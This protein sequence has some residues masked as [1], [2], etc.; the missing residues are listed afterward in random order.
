MRQ[1]RKRLFCLW[2]RELSHRSTAHHQAWQLPVYCLGTR[3]AIAVRIAARE[4]GRITSEEVLARTVSLP[5]TAVM[6]THLPENA[7]TCTS[8]T[9]R[10]RSYSQA[11]C[12][13]A[14]AV[15]QPQGLGL[16]NC[17]IIRFW[18]GL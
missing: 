8:T 16:E 6:P 3:A 13:L 11:V 18:T 15:D 9:I 2:R 4:A 17:N 7:M 5:N 10:C 14:C 1:L 12:F